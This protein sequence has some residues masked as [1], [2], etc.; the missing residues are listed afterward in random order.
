V[1]AAANIVINDGQ[2]SP[3][4]HTFVP[5]RKDGMKVDYD[6]RTTPHTPAGFY[7]IAISSTAPQSKS[8]VVRCKIS[9]AMP[10]E[11]YDSVTGLY[12]YPTT[13]RFNIDVLVPTSATSA[14][15]ADVYAYL[16][17]LMAHATVQSLIKDLDAPF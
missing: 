1:A 6:E 14:Q 13:A 4:A 3:A 15:R 10:L 2:G 5:A 12:S 17:N 9:L 8:P 11:S 16:K 7:T